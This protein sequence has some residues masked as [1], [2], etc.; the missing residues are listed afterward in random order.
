MNHLSES[1]KVSKEVQFATI[2][3]AIADAANSGKDY[4]ALVD[5]VNLLRQQEHELAS[6]ETQFSALAR[7]V[8]D[9]ARKDR[10]TAP[11][12]ARLRDLRNYEVTGIL[13]HHAA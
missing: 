7:Q 2:G 6:R 4:S 10:D 3:R 5:E 13:T 9:A 11:L 12:V 8:G 1:T